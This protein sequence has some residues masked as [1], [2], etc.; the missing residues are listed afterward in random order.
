MEHLL[1]LNDA[2]ACELLKLALCDV[3]A[4]KQIAVTLFLIISSSLVLFILLL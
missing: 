1:R 3:S 2:S 4:V